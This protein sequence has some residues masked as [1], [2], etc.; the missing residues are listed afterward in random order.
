MYKFG[1]NK[2]LNFNGIQVPTVNILFNVNS[3]IMKPSEIDTNKVVISDMVDYTIKSGSGT[4]KFK[5]IFVGYQVTDEK[6]TSLCIQA[7]KQDS[8]G[9]QK[10]NETAKWKVCFIRDETNAK[11]EAFVRC[12]EKV[13]ARVCELAKK[14]KHP[15]ITHIAANSPVKDGKIPT[16]CQQKTKVTDDGIERIITTAFYNKHRLQVDPKI[17]HGKKLSMVAAI[18]FRDVYLS[19]NALPEKSL[20]IRQAVVTGAHDAPKQELMIEVDDDDF[21]DDE[22]D[23]FNN[24]PP[25]TFADLE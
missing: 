23:D 12:L 21:S 17:Y 5:R 20:E 16:F 8:Y 1:Q 25:S 18:T 9:I 24:S 2:T 22:D 7:P 3:K 15:M 11:Q 19:S 6:I 10:Y 13:D 4:I 14:Y